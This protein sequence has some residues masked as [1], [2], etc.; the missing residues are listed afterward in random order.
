MEEGKLKIHKQ[1][2]ASFPKKQT[3]LIS[4]FGRARQGKSFMMNC[5]AGEKEIFRISNE[6]ESCTQG[7]DISTKWVELKEFAAIGSKS[8]LNAAKTLPGINVGFVDAEG[9]GDRD[10]GYD[11]N[12]ICPIL[13]A[14]KCVLFNWKGDLQKD[15]TLSTLGIMTRAAQNVSMDSGTSSLSSKRKFGHLHIVFRDWQAVGSDEASVR[16]VLFTKEGTSDGAIRDQIRT[17]VQESFESISIWLF[18]APSE[19]VKDLKKKLTID[20]TSLEF[21]SQLQKFRN[22]LTVQ[23]ISPTTFA[24]H[25][26]SGKS[27]TPL[28]QQIAASLNRGEVVL[29]T[30]AYASMIRVELDVIHSKY[31]AALTDSAEQVMAKLNT[32]QTGA[33]PAALEKAAM[34]LIQQR[35]FISDSFTA[36]AYPTVHQVTD[37]YEQGF[38]AVDAEFQKEFTRCVGDG[39]TDVA[40]S[41]RTEWTK[42]VNVYKS[43]LLHH[44]IPA[45]KNQLGKWVLARRKVAERFLTQAYSAIGSD[46]PTP[47]HALSKTL[48]AVER[49]ALGMVSDGSE[50]ASSE[51]VKDARDILLKQSSS[52]KQ[53]ALSSN[54]TKLANLRR[55]E[56]QQIA[57]KKEEARR[58]IAGTIDAAVKQ[59]GISQTTGYPLKSL[60]DVLNAK[61]HELDQW[62]DRAS[63]DTELVAEAKAAFMVDCSNMKDNMK[64]EYMA[65]RQ[66]ALQHSLQSQPVALSDRL[67][68]SFDDGALDAD[69]IESLPLQHLVAAKE[70]IAGWFSNSSDDLEAPFTKVDYEKRLRSGL[71]DV[72][73]H[74]IEVL[75]E[76]RRVEEEE[77]AEREREEEA[78][79]LAAQ[80]EEEEEEESEEEE[81]E[82][83]KPA[84]KGSKAVSSS[85]SS[86]GMSRAE[87]RERAK[88]YAE[89][90]LGLKLGKKKAAKKAKAPPASKAAPEKTVAQQRLAALNFAREKFGE[91]VLSPENKVA[92]D[93]VTGKA[94]ETDKK[95]KG[96]VKKKTAK[97]AVKEAPKRGKKLKGGDDEEGLE[98]AEGKKAKPMSVLEQAKE[99]ARQAMEVR[100]AN[101]KA[102]TKSTKKKK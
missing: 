41:L 61:Y 34:T 47:Q 59:L 50:V 5:L 92:G 26:L 15:H 51:E 48:D 79:L 24:G 8:G 98:D 93:K 62:L 91:G 75:N 23:L 83:V 84:G 69:I 95:G 9:Q 73:E 65:S 89:G 7:I 100:S 64:R 76:Q 28:I 60:E 1:A 96:K 52:L 16:K 36:G 49:T 57:D 74:F 13:L 17:D 39:N 43:S 88:R 58:T 2:Q 81:E 99:E 29:P 101:I 85:S 66:T 56:Q 42:R 6:K 31:E 37:C 53:T 12:L 68:R 54:Q 77:E 3:N 72:I 67:Q 78:A 70:A 102:P 21:Q 38:S 10:V 19:F 32:E 18:D 14:S 44:V 11:S 30:S 20:Q 87:Q 97:E 90:T 86:A 80:A 40:R 27:L 33:V 35:R 94:D 55:H 45:C 46:P 71:S 22:A 82:D 63:K 4:I 25:A